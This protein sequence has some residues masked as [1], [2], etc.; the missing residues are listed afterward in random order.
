MQYFA[1]GLLGGVENAKRVYKWHRASGYAVLLLLF[2]T[3]GAA[4]FTAFN[5]NSLHIK[6]RSV[7][8]SSVLVWV[9]IVPRIRLAKFGLRV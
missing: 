3:V 8:V 4:T 6:L 9:G 7:V 1:P 2:I 5:V